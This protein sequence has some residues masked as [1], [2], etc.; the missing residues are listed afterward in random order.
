MRSSVNYALMNCKRV[1]NKLSLARWIMLYAFVADK[2]A[3]LL[4]SSQHQ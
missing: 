2:A 1:D 3:R 4:S